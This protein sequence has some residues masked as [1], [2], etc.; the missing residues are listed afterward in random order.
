MISLPVSE[1][2]KDKE[3]SLCLEAATGTA[4]LSKKIMIPQIQKPGLALT[5]YTSNLHPG[6]IQVL[7]NSEIDFLKHQGG[8]Q[9]R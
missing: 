7:G 8:A 6:R 5:G 2:L 9:P 4:G 3:Y 1:L